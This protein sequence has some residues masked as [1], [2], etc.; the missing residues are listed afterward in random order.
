MNI[1]IKKAEYVSA[2][3]NL[4]K[5]GFSY[6]GVTKDRYGKKIILYSKDGI[7]YRFRITDISG[8]NPVIILEVYE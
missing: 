7:D 8:E 5:L 3:E 2:R 4:A 1:E 6:E